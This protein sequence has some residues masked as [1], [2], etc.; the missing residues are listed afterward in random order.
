MTTLLFLSLWHQEALTESS[1]E[2]IGELLPCSKPR[3]DLHPQLTLLEQ[4][5]PLHYWGDCAVLWVQDGNC[6]FFCYHLSVVRHSLTDAFQR[7]K[8]L[9]QK[10]PR[11]T[12]SYTT[13]GPYSN[14]TS[15]QRVNI[16]GFLPTL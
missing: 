11:A 10:T 2:K 12:S 16:V 7:L 5:Y 3:S 14:K 15:D 1:G 4:K 6:V 13:I 8:Q 9:L